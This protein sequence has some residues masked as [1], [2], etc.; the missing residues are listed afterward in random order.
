MKPIAIF[1]H[2]LFFMDDTIL[3]NACDIVQ[4]QMAQAEQSGLIDA[5]SH[6]VV[7][8]NGGSESLVIASLIFPS[9]ANVVLHGLDCK[10]ENL[11]ILEIERWVPSHPGWHVLYFHS[12]GAT[13]PR[14]DT[15]SANWRNCMM[16]HLVSNWNRCTDDLSLGYESVGCHWLTGQAQDKSQNLWA[17]TFWWAKSDFLSTLPSITAGGR[18]GMSGI[19]SVESRYEAEI[20]IGRGQRL[21]RVKDYHPCHPMKKQCS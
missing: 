13:K 21:P 10:N 1:Y 2:C 9:K 5:A 17:G 16:R 7:G 12:K 18:I 4:S 14:N 19:K 11:T 3:G 8:I 20:W 15:F 6:F